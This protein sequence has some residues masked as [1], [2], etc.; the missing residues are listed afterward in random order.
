MIQSPIFWTVLITAAIVYWQLPKEDR[1]SFLAVVSFGYLF[2]LEPVGSVL[3]VGFV[4]LFFLRRTHGHR[5]WQARECDYALAD[6]GDPGLPDLGEIRS[7]VCGLLGRHGAGD[8]DRRANWD[9]VFHLQA[10]PL[11]H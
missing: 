4:L 9:L 7:G 2:Y 8:A 5:G 10:D 3:L 6:R 11:R 1:F